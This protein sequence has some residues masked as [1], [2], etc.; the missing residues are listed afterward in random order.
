M[1]Q[2]VKMLSWY[3]VDH[4]NTSFNVCHSTYLVVAMNT[5]KKSTII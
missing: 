3:Q 5:W 1:Q 2:L 4:M